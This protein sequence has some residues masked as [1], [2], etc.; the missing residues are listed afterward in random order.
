[1]SLTVQG[2]GRW[3]GKPETVE[4]GEP[5]RGRWIGEVVRELAS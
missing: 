2:D 3:R 5:D 4:A 1:M